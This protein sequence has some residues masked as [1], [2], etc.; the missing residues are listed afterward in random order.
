MISVDKPVNT[1]IRPHAI[2]QDGMMTEG[3]SNQCRNMFLEK[4]YVQLSL[5]EGQNSPW[6]LHAN[7][8]NK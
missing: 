3:L 1:D 7:V 8:S 5:D 2:I 6:H 4:N